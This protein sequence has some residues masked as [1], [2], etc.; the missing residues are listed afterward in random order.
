V[1]LAGRCALVTGGAVRVGRALVLALAGEG[2]RLVVHYGSSR[3]EAE[4]L[5]GEIRQTG[6]QA[7]SISADLARVEEVERLAREAEAAF[8]GVDV[9]VNNASVFPDAGLD[10][11]TPELWDHT[12]AVNLRAPFFL[13]QRLGAAMQGRGGGVIVNLA[14][15]AGLQAW[16]GYAAHGISKAALVH[17]TRVAARALAPE[18]RVVAIAPGTVLPP[19]NLSQAE[20]ERLAQRAPLRRNGSPEDVVRALL[21]AL[22]ADFVTGEVLAVD[23]GRLLGTS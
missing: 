23:G 18:V 22:R 2:M 15:L 11:T 13:T 21:Y 3:E 16:R 12:L 1:E 5:V 9:L 20:V 14:D 6:G 19:E 17:L 7:I 4:G 10:D 8:G